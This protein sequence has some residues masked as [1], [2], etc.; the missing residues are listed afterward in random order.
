MAQ[1][2]SG[3]LGYDTIYA[4]QDIE[5]DAKIGVKSTARL[6]GS[7]VKPAIGL[8][9]SATLLLLLAVIWLKGGSA[10]IPAPRSLAASS[11]GSIKTLDPYGSRITPNERFIK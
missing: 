7:A 9:Y 11:T 1:A 2:F 4:L 6:F 10:G 3:R 8:F 5:D